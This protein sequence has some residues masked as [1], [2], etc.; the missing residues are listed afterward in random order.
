[1]VQVFTNYRAAQRGTEL[2]ALAALLIEKNIKVAEKPVAFNMFINDAIAF[3]MKPEQLLYFSEYAFGTAD[4]IIYRPPILRIHDLKTGV[5]KPSIKQLEIY[6]ALFCLEYEPNLTDLEF[7][8]RIYQ[9][10]SVL[11]HFSEIDD[12]VH[13]MNKIRNFTKLLNE[14]SKDME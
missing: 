3:K 5:S 9:N 7:H 11:E 8:L 6:A 2:H 12:I 14:V 13:I 4:A 10:D 1:M